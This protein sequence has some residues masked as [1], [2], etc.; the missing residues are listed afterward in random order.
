VSEG[1]AAKDIVVTQL[2]VSGGKGA[3]GVVMWRGAIHISPEMRSVAP[4]TCMDQL[5]GRASSTENTC[6]LHR[7]LIN[8]Q[9]DLK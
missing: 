6:A 3:F 2:A 4:E 7:H 8:C 5:R 1:A 9:S